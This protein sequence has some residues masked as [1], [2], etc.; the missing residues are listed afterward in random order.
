[1]KRQ[2]LLIGNLPAAVPVAPIAL[3]LFENV[4]HNEGQAGYLCK[5]PGDRRFASSGIAEH[6]NFFHD[7]TCLL[8]G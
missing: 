1:M 4:Q 7:E 2:I 8:D 3:W 6:G 5:P